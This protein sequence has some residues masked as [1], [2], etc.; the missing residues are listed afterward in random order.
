MSQI[1]TLTQQKRTLEQC[2]QE[3][4]SGATDTTKPLI[5]QIDELRK[6]LEAKEA[7]NSKMEQSLLEKISELE[8]NI[9]EIT[10]IKEK[11]ENEISN[12][13]TELNKTKSTINNIQI[14]NNQL[15]TEIS[16]ERERNKMISV[17]H[18]TLQKEFNKLSQ[19]LNQKDKLYKELKESS[20]ISLLKLKE[21]IEYK[22]NKILSLEDKLQKKDNEISASLRSSISLNTPTTPIFSPRLSLS[23]SDQ[24]TGVFAIEIAHYQ[25]IIKQQSGEIEV[26]QNRLKTLETARD[27]LAEELVSMS[28]ASNLL[29]QEKQEIE[30]LKN[31]IK[32]CEQRESL[33]LDLVGEKEE[34]IDDMN[35]TIV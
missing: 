15:Q 34:K 1:H 27:S 30:K 5:N 6:E 9:Q 32:E 26:L 22:S 31:K 13:K 25:T 7:S 10:K 12:L 17:Q 28:E 2:L 23:T 11:L 21:E 35:E 16:E 14:Q 4:R 24:P 19:D 29:K 33:L 18:S 8:N 3:L 20:T